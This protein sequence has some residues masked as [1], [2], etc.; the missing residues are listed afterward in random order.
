MQREA[1]DCI[2]PPRLPMCIC[3]HR[4]SLRQ[5]TRKPLMPTEEEVAANSR[6]R[7]ARLR[8][9]EKLSVAS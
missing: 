3:G 4:A 7:S 5:V 6:S 8:I 9:A 2:C 1:Q